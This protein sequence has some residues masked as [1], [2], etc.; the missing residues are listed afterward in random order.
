MTNNRRFDCKLQISTEHEQL[1]RESRGAL[2][3]QELSKRIDCYII[4]QSA[5][6]DV[7]VPQRNKAKYLSFFQNTVEIE[8]CGVQ[9][10]RSSKFRTFFPL[11]S[12]PQRKPP[13]FYPTTAS[14]SRK[15][16]VTTRPC[17]HIWV[18][19]SAVKHFQR[20]ASVPRNVLTHVF[21]QQGPRLCYRQK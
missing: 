16:K 9:R 12:K 1:S 21:A 13:T 5:V 18:K 20:S 3:L 4:N 19:R 6:E 2:L 14:I 10:K 11:C 17:L 7:E 8:D 15:N